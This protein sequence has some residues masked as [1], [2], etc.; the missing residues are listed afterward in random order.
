MPLAKSLATIDFLSGGRLIVGVGFGG[1]QREFDAV[2]IPFATRGTRAV[3][4]I[5]LMKRLWREDHVERRGIFFKTT[6]LSVGPQ[7]TQRPHPPIWMGGTADT[8]LKRVG[9]LAEATS[10]APVP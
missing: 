7:T 3:E 9:A 8:V 6:D 2:E 5:E 10:A 4:Q 1:S